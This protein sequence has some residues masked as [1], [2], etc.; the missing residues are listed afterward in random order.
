MTEPLVS[1]DVA[2]LA[3][4]EVVGEKYVVESTI[5]EGAFAVVYGARHQSIASLRVA[6]KALKPSRADSEGVRRRFQREA[7]T[8]A[9][10]NSPFSVRVMDV[11]E[12]DAG[13]PY[14][15]LEYIDGEPLDVAISRA[16]RMGDRVVGMIAIQVLHALNEAHAHGIMHRDIKPA[17]LMLVHDKKR[18]GINMKVLDFGIARIF[19]DTVLPMGDGTVT[20]SV[21]CTPLYASPEVLRGEPSSLGDIYALGISLIQ[22]LN[23]RPPYLAATAYQVANMH[24]DPRPV[25]LGPHASTS[26]LA[27]IIRRA[28]EKNP[29]NRYASAGD[30]L[31]DLEREFRTE[32]GTGAL[33]ARIPTADFEVSERSEPPDASTSDSFALA[34]PTQVLPL[35]LEP[36]DA[37][38]GGQ[39]GSEEQRVR[40]VESSD[41]E[42]QGTGAS[43]AVT[44]EQVAFSRPKAAT[45]APQTASPTTPSPASVLAS[46]RDG[47]AV[48]S[49]VALLRG[50]DASSSIMALL[51]G[52]AFILAAILLLVVA[53][54]MVSGTNAP[55]TGV[56]S[57]S[58][59]APPLAAPSGVPSAA[60]SGMPIGVAVDVELATRNQATGV[61]MNVADVVADVV[62]SAEATNTAAASEQTAQRVATLFRE[63]VE[64][65]PAPPPVREPRQRAE[66]R[67]RLEP[68]STARDEGRASQAD[69]EQPE[70]ES[71]EDSEPAN[72]FGGLQ[73]M[74]L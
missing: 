37:V 45:V 11:G 55:A 67:R 35:G 56:A 66:R 29:L 23:G 17:N 13:I 6:I 33:S 44:K 63:P 50:S 39:S 2:P 24:L 47:P 1:A 69:S 8:A 51:A 31:D 36:F 5:G 15:V 12:T 32:L 18:G 48:P 54:P 28:T 7:L 42:A 71:R 59:E 3:I 72:P 26:R 57:G 64:A 19:D 61:A 9:S 62:A 52:A 43:P 65:A 10:L 25:P 20:T 46:E 53:L 41:F 70:P 16:G 21:H 68:V 60:P 58:S 14:M 73:P 4:G 40:L 22:A 38:V 34:L 30:M 27:P 74:G 49:L